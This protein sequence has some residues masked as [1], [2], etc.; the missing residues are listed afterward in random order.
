M[1][2]YH[3]Q[4]KDDYCLAKVTEVH[5]DEDGLVRKVT[6]TYRKRNPRESAQIYKSKPLICEQVA[7]HRLHR[8]DLADEDVPGQVDVA[9]GCPLVQA[10]DSVDGV[11]GQVVE[12]NGGVLG[13][14]VGQ[15]GEGGAGVLVHDAGLAY[16]AG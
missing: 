9:A 8:L 6:V 14:D 15:V 13:H 10:D 5:P 2:R 3:K 7:I 1:L 11:L 16:E 4:F 12:G